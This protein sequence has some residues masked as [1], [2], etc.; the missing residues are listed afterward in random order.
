MV[1]RQ[2]AS[3]GTS[4]TSTS[5][6]ISSGMAMAGWVS[7]NWMAALSAR[8]RTSPCWSD[9]AV[10]QVLQRRGGEEILLAQPQ[11]LPGRG[12]VA[13]VEHLGD[14][15]GMCPLGRGADVVAAIECIQPQRVGGPGRPQPQRVG[16]VA[17]PADDRRVIGDRGH[18]LARAPDVAGA[19]VRRGHRLDRAAEA[20][21]VADVGT[22]EL[23][24]VAEGEPV[25]RVFEL[26]AVADLLAEQAVV[27]ADAVA[28][29]GDAEAG[30]ALHEAGRQPAQPAIAKRG[31]G[32]RLAQPVEV[33]AEFRQGR[34][35]L[36]GQAEVGQRIGQ[37]AAEQELEGEVVDALGMAC[38]VGAGRGH[39]ALG[40]VVAGGERGGDEPVPV[41]GDDRVAADREGELGDDKVAQGGDVLALVGQGDAGSRVAGGIHAGAPPWV[42]WGPSSGREGKNR[43]S[44][45]AW[46]APAGSL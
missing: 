21:G 17:T 36:A 27:V 11:L 12:V 20:D 5:S 9:V 35:H 13:G 31:V 46:I 14:R 41:G 1:I 7:F 10:E 32:F 44:G 18:R 29:G 39:P 15:V 24:R 19:A 30:H 8:V 4:C 45:W 38:V 6:R 22:G 3:Q 23:P 40:D 28:V 25:L 2:A 26:P 33:H 34:A 16:I 43:L 37:Q 42:G